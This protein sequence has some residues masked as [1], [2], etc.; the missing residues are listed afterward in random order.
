MTFLESP[1]RSGWEISHKKGAAMIT[2]RERDRRRRAQW[3]WGAITGAYYPIFVERFS[4]RS[5]MQ[6]MTYIARSRPT[7][8]CLSLPQ[9]PRQYTPYL[10]VYGVEIGVIHR[11][12]LG[13]VPI[14]RYEE[15][16][17]FWIKKLRERTRRARRRSRRFEQVLQVTDSIYRKRKALKRWN[18]RLPEGG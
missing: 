18:P 17:D 14:D 10:C 15:L 9:D 3:I 16:P 7:C 11:G 4:N 13:A 1:T 2:K 5:R 12:C 6:A 8:S